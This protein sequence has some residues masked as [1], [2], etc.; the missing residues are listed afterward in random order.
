M[1]ILPVFDKQ[2]AL[3]EARPPLSDLVHHRCLCT[4]NGLWW[5]IDDG[6]VFTIRCATNNQLFGI[7]QAK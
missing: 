2:G 5:L 7:P 6:H 1:T 4:Q 3:F